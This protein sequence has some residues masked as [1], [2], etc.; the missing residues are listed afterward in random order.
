MKNSKER[1]YE[2]KEDIRI[3]AGDAVKTIAT[4]AE[5]AA[6]TIAQAAAEA[7]KVANVKSSDDH[8]LIIK[9]DTKMDGLKEDIKALND[10]TSAKISD[11]E[12]RIKALEISI[13]KVFT[14]GAVALII[15]GI[16]QFLVGKYF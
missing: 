13:T 7:L 5:N 3:A 12:L 8:D 16:V 1:E 11:H 14:F 10:G 4:A 9:L 15:L 2:A 6:K